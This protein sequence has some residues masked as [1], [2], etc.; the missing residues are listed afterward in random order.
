MWSNKSPQRKR[1]FPHA[2]GKQWEIKVT[3]E[4]SFSSFSIAYYATQPVTWGVHWSIRLS[5]YPYFHL[6]TSH[7]LRASVKTPVHVC[8]GNW[9]WHGPFDVD[10]IVPIFV[11][12][13]SLSQYDLPDL[14][15]GGAFDVFQWKSRSE[16]LKL[17][18][19]GPRITFTITLVYEVEATEE[20]SALKLLGYKLRQTWA[21]LIPGKML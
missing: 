11:G 10:G 16:C 7:S 4:L 5:I 8:P 14:H 19:L 21:Q 17:F 15:I 1:L 6:S 9:P 18:L 20:K 3:D 12:I 2:N 13:C